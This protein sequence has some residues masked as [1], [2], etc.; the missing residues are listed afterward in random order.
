MMQ[1]NLM[2]NG[3]TVAVVVGALALTGCKEA[4][5]GANAGTTPAGDPTD[6]TP[7]S[8]PNNGGTSTAGNNSGG[9]DAGSV[10]FND[11]SAEG[12]IN[13]YINRL[14]AVDFL[15]A[16]EICLPEAPGTGE[17]IKLGTNI[18][19]MEASAETASM[20]ETTRALFK[21]DFKTLSAVKTVEEEGVAVYEVSVINKAPVNV[22]VE[23]RDGVWRVIP[24]S[25]GTPIS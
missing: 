10:A 14:K 1:K 15:G 6:A 16:A 4:G 9:G 24:P 7:T 19:N 17:L 22:R 20:A 21:G 12:A 13:T 11:L 25:D 18:G 23:Q 5:S 8:A 2:K 3:I